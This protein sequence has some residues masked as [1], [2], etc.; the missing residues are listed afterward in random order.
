M[1]LNNIDFNKLDS[2]QE[3]IQGL[4][5]LISFVDLQDRYT[6]VTDRVARLCGFRTAA[7]MIG[8]KDQE[9]KCAVAKRAP[10]FQEENHSVIDRRAPKVFMDIAGPYA[11]DQFYVIYYER[12]PLFD[13]VNEVKGVATFA[14]FYSPDQFQKLSHFLFLSSKKYLDN[15]EEARYLLTEAQDDELN[16]T[17]RE[18]ECLYFILRGK[19]AAEMGRILNISIKTIEFHMTN[20]KDKF[21]VFSKSSLIEKALHLGYLFRIPKSLIKDM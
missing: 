15:G 16:L 14:H 21:R 20:L 19:T 11:D 7:A 1:N 8:R 13:A 2:F 3:S 17:Q 9:L 5:L 10:Q 18:M 6:V 12:V 4:P